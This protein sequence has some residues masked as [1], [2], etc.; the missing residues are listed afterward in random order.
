MDAFSDRNPAGKQEFTSSGVYEFNS[1]VVLKFKDAR[2]KQQS[3]ETGSVWV[4]VR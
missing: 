1:G 4:T 3:F 2:G